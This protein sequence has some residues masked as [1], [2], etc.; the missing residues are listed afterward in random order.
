MELQKDARVT[1]HVDEELREAAE[2]LFSRM[3]TNMNDAF[4]VFLRKTVDESAIFG[5]NYSADDITNAFTGIVQL[6]MRAAKERG[7]PLAKYDSE[8]RQAYLEAPDGS[9]EYV[10][11]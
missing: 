11:G 5:R 7:S 8:K 6:E 10:N 1:F 9:R 3:G 2:A 4:N